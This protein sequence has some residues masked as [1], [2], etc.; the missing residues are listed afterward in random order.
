M[1][2][3]YL[4]LA[5]M[6]AIGAMCVAP[7][8][9]AFAQ[10][11]QFAFADDGGGG[12]LNEDDY[13]RMSG[14]IADQGI[15]IARL[16]AAGPD[17]LGDGVASIGWGDALLLALEKLA[18]LV[19]AG[20]M[21]LVSIVYTR[22]TGNKLE[23]DDA[24]RYREYL[25]S[26]YQFAVNA[27]APAFRG[28]K[29]TVNEAS[30]VVEWMLHYAETLFPQLLEQFGGKEA[31]RMRAWSIVD[32]AEGEAIPLASPA[33]APIATRTVDLTGGGAPAPAQAP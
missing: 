1:R 13:A 8:P 3:K 7:A 31:A 9:A 25:Q 33:A 15:E 17:V 4:A 28:K 5:A 21:I 14:N 2:V 27:I 32:L 16:T 26:A 20:G 29:L 18:W 11:R 19:I 24:A 10:E 22:V 12:L 6:M 30:P 23:A